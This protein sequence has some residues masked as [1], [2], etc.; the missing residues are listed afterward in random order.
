MSDAESDGIPILFF[1][2]RS[3]LPVHAHFKC[4]N[5]VIICFE[6]EIERESSAAAE[7]EILVTSVPCC[8]ER[9]RLDLFNLFIFAGEMMIQRESLRQIR[10]GSTRYAA[11]AWEGNGGSFLWVSF[12]FHFN[13]RNLWEWKLREWRQLKLSHH[14]KHTLIFIDNFNGL[15]RHNYPISVA[16]SA[17]PHRDDLR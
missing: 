4:F 15:M 16:S 7:R 2:F 6:V 3:S 11:A 9:L 13:S 1:V 14:A 10:H 12:N 8:L 17:A 5:S